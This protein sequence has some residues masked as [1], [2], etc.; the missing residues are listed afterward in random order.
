MGKIV[1]TEFITVDGVIDSPGGEPGFDRGGWAFQFNRGDEGDK[2]K[3]DE[4]RDASALLLGRA[5]YEG[6]ARAWPS[7]TDEVG[8]ADKMNSMPK[9]VVSATLGSPTWNNST[10]ISGNLANEI[11]RLK[12]EL[13]GDILVA[14]SATLVR[15]L[16]EHGLADEY[17]LMV[18]PVILGAGKRLFG[19]TSA[20]AALRLADAKPVGP[21]GVLLVTYVPDRGNAG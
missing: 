14:G 11:A 1:V 15:A 9:Y 5:T 20:T 12:R 6:F 19:D 13:D 3:L 8:F 2:F 16:T 4:I 21:D 10:V 18:F 7:M 17:R